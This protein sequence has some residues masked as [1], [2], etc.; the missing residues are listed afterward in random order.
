MDEF[1][2]S[3]RR[4]EMRNTIIIGATFGIF[5][6]IGDVWSEFLR[7]VVDTFAPIH[8]NEVIN[9][10]IYAFITSACCIIIL[11]CIVKTNFYY[12]KASDK[13]VMVRK[14]NKPIVLRTSRN[15]YL[16]RRTQTKPK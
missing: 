8:E 13:L 10:T 12:Q 15:K 7:A 1:Q 6:T 11:V 4:L 14:Q 9:A 2:N 5:L 16:Q 3:A